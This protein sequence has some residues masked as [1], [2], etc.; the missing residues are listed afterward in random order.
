MV[1]FGHYSSGPS[2]LDSIYFFNPYSKM[3]KTPITY[4][5][6]KLSLLSEI[7]PLIPQ[8][9]TYTESFFGGGS[10]FFAK[11]PAKSEI[12]NDANNMVVNFFQVIQTEF[13][14]LKEKIHATPYS[15]STYSVAYCIYQMPH[16]FG[17]VEQAWAFY[18]VTNL[19]FSG[20]IGSWAYDSDGKRLRS[21]NR[22]KAAFDQSIADRLNNIQIEN[23]DANKV[24][25]S[26]DHTEAF[27]YVD[28]PYMDCNQGHYSG[29]SSVD[30]NTLLKSLS[31]IK[32]KF[33]LSCY[34]SLMLDEFIQ[35]KGWHHKSIR[36][37]LTAS[38]KKAGEKRQHKIEMLVA[39]Y[40]IH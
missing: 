35:R 37:P 36:K 6:G 39:N 5:G 8:H 18:V 7:L 19:G 3:L 22:K 25:L 15:R 17:K 9:Q 12:I 38:L 33:L 4:Y 34:P 29:Y 10:V 26:R 14:E 21:F 30:F 1:I 31:N 24:I 28:P 16:L 11:S 13:E 40:P 32:G 23:N 20:R 2:S 27:H